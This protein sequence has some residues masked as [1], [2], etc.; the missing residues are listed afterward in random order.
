MQTIKSY[1][2]LQCWK[3]SV[4]L[5]ELVYTMCEKAGLPTDDEL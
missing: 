1:E 4:E 3:L 2:D 5:C